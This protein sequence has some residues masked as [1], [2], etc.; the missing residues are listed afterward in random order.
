MARIIYA[1]RFEIPTSSGLNPVLAAY[2][3]WIEGHYRQRRG[4][5]SFSYD[6]SVDSPVPHVPPR[7]IILLDR[8]SGAKG[9]VVRLRWAYPSDADENLEWRNDIRIGAFGHVC[10]VE[11]LISIDWIDYRITPP[12]FMLGSPSVIRHL[13]SEAAVHIGEMLVKAAPYPL[14]AGGVG[15]FS[16]LLH[17]PK[18]RLPIVLVAPYANGDSNALDATLLAQHL[19]GVGIVVSAVDAEATWDIADAL[20]RT[21]SC[22]NGGARIYWPGFSAKSDPRS[23]RLY[24]GA[25]IEA[26][27]AD[28]VARSIERSIFAIAAFRFVPDPRISEVV[29]EAEQADR[30]QRAEVQ[31]ASS[32]EDWEAYA[33]ELDAKLAAANE[34]IAELQA[35]NENLKANQQVFFSAR[36]LGEGEDGAE[37]EEVAP[38]DSVEA[39]LEQ[40]RASCENLVVLDS[41][42]DAARESPFQ[43]PAEVL[44]ALRDL[45]EIA[46][47]WAKQRK[48]KGSGG[49]LLQHLKSRGWGKRS[50]MHISN[51]TRTKYGEHYEFEYDGKRQAFEPH[52]TIGSGDP[53]SCASIHFQLDQAR[54]KVVVA[55]V[56]KHLPN[57]KT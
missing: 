42:L 22:F 41:A 53:N 34:A 50:S 29:R 19:A 1:C 57:T 12:Q 2:S 52:I 4:L 47:D 55:H 25:R 31:K 16:E 33:L 17:S 7:H 3:K 54:E 37:I 49:D 56:G 14:E 48:E 35:E 32:G 18:R 46:V 8:F 45:D 15:E 28:A 44:S 11:H 39:A 24:L 27:G 13:C 10:S 43:R 21:L 38:P 5:S 6:L 36:V 30:L 51:T 20:G 26:L 23:H 40:A 9:D